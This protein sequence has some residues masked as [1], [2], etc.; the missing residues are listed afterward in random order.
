VVQTALIL[1]MTLAAFGLYTHRLDAQSIWSDEGLTMY[2]SAHDVRF[3]L[4]GAIYVEG[5]RTQDAQPPLYFLLL[6]MLRRLAGGSVWVARFYSA[7][8]GALLVPL[9]YVLGR[10]LAGWPVGAV[11]AGLA[12]LSPVYLWYAQEARNY[13]MAVALSLAS[14]YCQVRMLGPQAWALTG[15]TSSAQRSSSYRWAAGCI[16]A[17]AAAVYTH[18]L[19]L[20][21]A[22]FEVLVVLILVARKRHWRAVLPLA[23][24]A[25]IAVPVMPFLLGRWRG[26]AEWNY[27]YHSLS[28]VLRTAAQGYILGLSSDVNRL[29]G[30]AL[31]LA[32]MVVLGALV[33]A[34]RRSLSAAYL[35]GYLVVPAVGVWVLSLVKPIFQGVRHILLASPPFYLLLAAGIV[36]LWRWRWRWRPVAVAT[37]ALAV[38]LMLHADMAYF[39]AAHVR[40]DDLRGLMRWLDRHAHHGDVIA[41]SDPI[42]LHVFDTYIQHG[43]VPRV[44][45]PSFGT[46]YGHDTLEL[47]DR[48][49]AEYERICFAHGPPGTFYDPL[50]QARGWLEANLQPTVQAHFWG[51]NVTVGATCYATHAVVSD[52][53]PQVGRSV[54]GRFEGG[55]ELVGYDQP[56]D[57]ASG[58]GAIVPLLFRVHEPQPDN[59]KLALRLIGPDGTSWGGLDQEPFAGLFPTS[60]WPAGRFVRVPHELITQLGAPPGEYSL[61]LFL[62]DEDSGQRRRLAGRSEHVLTLGPARVTPGQAGQAPSE[63]D[64][65]QPVRATWRA[66]DQGDDWAIQLLGASKPDS[67]AAPGTEVLLDVVFRPYGRIPADMAV[68]LELRSGGSVIA[69]QDQPP[70]LAGYPASAWRPGVAVRG[71]YRLT[72]PADMPAGPADIVARLISR[73]AHTG[74]FAPLGGAQP[75]VAHLRVSVPMRS[76]KAPAPEYTS[77]ATFGDSMRLLGYDVVRQAGGVWVATLYWRAEDRVPKNYVVSLQI[78]P[79]AGPPV[80]QHD[81]QPVDGG[82]PTAGWL[83][84]EVVT[85]RRELS[86]PPTRQAEVYTLIVAV[87]DPSN[88]QRLTVSDGSVTNDHAV[89]TALGSAPEGGIGLGDSGD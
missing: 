23:A 12:A 89:L 27:S 43:G 80:S 51:R 28:T 50:G 59:L 38:V 58:Q 83:P 1:G 34:R 76:F 69:A 5:F 74:E 48:L 11:A 49:T 4:S 22:A 66:S 19:A 7:A 39:T 56:P 84:G 36:Y 15:P 21:V 63:D 57:I 35:T 16:V 60:A 86:P 13:T 79:P 73:R 2:R 40:R 42:M 24:M 85:D 45:L 62:Y 55:L 14:A 71:R 70:T 82:R 53:R 25:A 6:G 37:A 9:V 72:V 87:Y 78:I 88:G 81:G 52:A 17:L 75:A 65:E 61:Q 33:T 44:G 8:F 26:G 3:I 77:R 20:L 41:F 54:A 47:L 30:L 68:R 32:G 18:Y 10:R 31:A 67:S 64:I 46:F 29:G